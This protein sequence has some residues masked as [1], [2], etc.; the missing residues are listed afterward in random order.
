[1]LTDILSIVNFIS[2]III[3][4]ILF[5]KNDKE[6]FTGAPDGYTNLLV[7]DPDGNLNT[8]SLSQLESDISAQIISSLNGYVKTS[9]L[10]GYVKNSDLN[11]YV[12]NSDLNGTLTSYLKKGQ[13]A[14][15]YLGKPSEATQCKMLIGQDAG[16]V[17]IGQGGY[18]GTCS[19][20][21]S[22]FNQQ[23]TFI[24]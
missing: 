18:S 13:S 12:K 7:S 6:N 14:M 4:I 11:G 21:K 15:L 23:W 19:P 8:F 16:G 10:N 9:D 22:G 17:E 24:W 3:F 5:M 1:M 2:I 20:V